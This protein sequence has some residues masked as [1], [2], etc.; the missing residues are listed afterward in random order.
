MAIKLH[1]DL[2]LR[3]PKSTKGPTT[4]K[5]KD[6]HFDK[7]ITRGNTAQHK[8]ETAKEHQQQKKEQ[9]KEEML[10]K[11][12]KLSRFEVGTSLGKT[13]STWKDNE[14]AQ[15]GEA[16]CKSVY[17]TCIIQEGQAKKF[18]TS[19]KE[20]MYFK[21]D[22]ATVHQ[23]LINFNQDPEAILGLHQALNARQE[24]RS[25]HYA[26]LGSWERS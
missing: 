18:I 14:D 6:V 19:A 22:M 13:S 7:L 5:K 3:P 23:V 11:A 15:I 12:L 8:E 1:I 26:K 9:T 17:E 4:P 21:K 10:L 2:N 25:Q 24:E 20:V 16:L